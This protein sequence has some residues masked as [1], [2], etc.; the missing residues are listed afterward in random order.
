MLHYGNFHIWP[1]LYH[2]NEQAYVSCEVP[3][4]IEII[5]NLY[6]ISVIFSSS[7][8]ILSGYFEHE[9]K[10]LITALVKLQKEIYSVS[11]MY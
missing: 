8:H 2:N 1:C 7:P 4:Q 6:Y 11:Y 3:N 9:M 10:N 5:L